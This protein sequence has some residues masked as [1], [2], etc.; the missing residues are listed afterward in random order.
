M[1]S[2]RRT[3]AVLRAVIY[4]VSGAL[5]L[6]TAVHPMRAATPVGLLAGLSVVGLAGGAL[7]WA[8]SGRVRWWML[9]AAVAVMGVLIGV[10]AWRSATAVGIVGLGPVLISLALYAAHF[11]SLLAARLHAAGMVTAATVGALAAAP[12]GF[13]MPWLAMVVSALALAAVQGRLLLPGLG[14]A[15]LAEP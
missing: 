4:A 13:T 5:C 6:A 12:G 8:G 1:Q 14:F 10:V 7:L 3:A 11:F 2:E 9:H 15:W